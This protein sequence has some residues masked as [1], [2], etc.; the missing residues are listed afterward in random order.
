MWGETDKAGVHIKVDISHAYATSGRELDMLPLQHFLFNIS[1]HNLSEEINFSCLI[2]SFALFSSD[3][4][5]QL[6]LKGPDLWHQFCSNKHKI[7]VT[8]LSCDT[9][10][11]NPSK[12]HFEQIYCL[13][14]RTSP[15]Q[16]TV[17]LATTIPNH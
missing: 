12:H 6:E 3:W 16:S 7:I 14:N 1:R 8:S 13:L 11:L 5:R 10:L 2:I 17:R 9:L 15:S 4:H